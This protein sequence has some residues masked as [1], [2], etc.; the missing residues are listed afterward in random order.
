M[1]G[2]DG[3]M[4]RLERHYHD[5]AER[6]GIELEVFNRLKAGMP[7]KIGRVDAIVIFTNKISH[8]AKKAAVDTAKAKRIPVLMSHSCGVS[9]LRGC[10]KNLTGEED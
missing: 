10:F 5:E 4:D 3:G 6:H 8:R 9:A 1:C 2:V 7:S